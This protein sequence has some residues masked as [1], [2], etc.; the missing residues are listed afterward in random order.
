MFGKYWADNRKSPE[1]NFNQCIYLDATYHYQW[2]NTS[3]PIR[4]G[5][6]FHFICEHEPFSSLRN[7]RRPPRNFVQ[8]SPG[9]A[10]ITA[11][12]D[13]LTTSSGEAEV[14]QPEARVDSIGIVLDGPSWLNSVGNDTVVL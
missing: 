2:R 14:H 6:S 3:C 4:G 12:V 1:A 11:L 13:R 7:S 5:P 8:A 10:R 9:V